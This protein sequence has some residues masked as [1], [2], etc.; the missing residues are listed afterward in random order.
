MVVAGNSV[1]VWVALVR[2][3]RV[4][5][6]VAAF[7]A[8]SRAL[9]RVLRVGRLPQTCVQAGT[10]GHVGGAKRRSLV[11]MR[12]R[13]WSAGNVK[14]ART[15]PGLHCPESCLARPGALVRSSCRHGGEVVRH[16]GFGRLRCPSGINSCAVLV[17]AKPALERARGAWLAAPNLPALVH[18]VVPSLTQQKAV[19]ICGPASEGLSE[20]LTCPHSVVNE[21]GAPEVRGLHIISHPHTGRTLRAC[22]IAICRLE[23]SRVALNTA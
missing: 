20:G 4:R 13:T 17:G 3:R 6:V 22:V 14:Q 5:A 19:P 9:V 2:A 10:A 15:T 23:G 8:L 1:V 16:A 11:P 18:E 7:S 12:L 21:S